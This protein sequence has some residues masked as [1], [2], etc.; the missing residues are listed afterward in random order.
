LSFSGQQGGGNPAAQTLSLSNTGGGTLTW[1]A[2]DNAAWLTLSPT[3]GSGNGTITVS[4]AT[5]SL[6]AG[7]YNATITLSAT[8]A[9]NVSVP[10][11]FTVAPAPTSITLSPSSLSYAGVQ[12]GANPPNQ[13]VTVTANG[14]W[15]A[16]SNSA[17]L[18]LNPTSGSGN[19]TITASV[20]LASATVGTNS[21][22]IT[23]TGGGTTR[24]VGVTL[25]VSAAS[26]TLSP[27]S[28]SFTAT[29]GAANPAG[30]SLTIS[31]NVA[32]TASDNAAWLSVSPSSG[33][34]NGSIT[35]S[36]NTSSA[37][38]GTN[39]AAITVTGGGI[40]RTVN[41]TLTLNAPATSSATL[42][43]N[44]NTESDLAGYKI[45]RATSSGTYGAPIATL[46][47]NVTSYVAT[48]LQSGTT[49][50]FVV[51]AY[52]SAGNESVYSNEVSKSIF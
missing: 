27:S 11:T 15:N 32:W 9:T 42:T 12:G 37:S 28:L 17:W 33:A 48:G 26:L 6:T 3:T 10:V 23:V 41:V 1:S 44:A 35:A 34:T 8:G 5:G 14:T 21:G 16:S 18:T 20:S 13:S 24:T 38:L 25:T 49:Y 51:T 31:S 29:Q 19:G 4:A 22:T 2:S 52:D 46:Q 36:V 47:G 7:T 45:Y 43:W 40:T 30:Q 39:T 50:F